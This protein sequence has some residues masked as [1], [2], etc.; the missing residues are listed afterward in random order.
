MSDE[1]SHLSET[2]SQELINTANTYTIV[3]M[4]EGTHHVAGVIHPEH[5]IDNPF[6]LDLSQFIPNAP[7]L[8][9]GFIDI[10]TELIAD[11]QAREG[12]VSTERVQVVQE[13][14]PDM[15]AELG[16]E[17]ISVKI[18]SREPARMSRD[19]KSRPNRRSGHAYE[20]INP[21]EPNKVLCVESRPIDHT[22]E[23]AAWGKT[24]TLANR[25]ALW[26]ER[27]LVAHTWAFTSKGVKPF[28]WLKRGADTVWTPS[29][30]RLHQRPLQFSA[31]MW[32]Y[33]VLAYPTLREFELQLKVSS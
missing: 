32:E 27:L 13:Y 14:P 4:E 25:R 20:Y 24:S 11:A 5:P 33:T 16:D 2:V 7:V 6:D 30:T 21:G 26:L 22:I 18:I 17:I 12:T 29:S 28:L 1:F 3:V 31:R 8:Y 9:E 15:I 23:I 19:G 10:L